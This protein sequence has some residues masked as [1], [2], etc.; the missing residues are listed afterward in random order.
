MAEDTFNPD[1]HAGFEELYDGEILRYTHPDFPEAHIGFSTVNT[2][3]VNGLDS[4]AVLEK[5]CPG[6]GAELAATMI[7]TGSAHG[8]RVDT[9]ADAAYQCPEKPSDRADG[10]VISLP[11]RAAVIPVADCL[12]ITILARKKDA[13]ADPMLG[14]LHAGWKGIR[15]GAQTAIVQAFQNSLDIPPKDLHVLIG[16]FGSEYAYDVYVKDAM[17]EGKH[18]INVLKEFEQAMDSAGRPLFTE[19]ILARAFRPHPDNTAK[20]YLDLGALATYLFIKAGV[21]EGQITLSSHRTI[22]EP[23]FRSSRVQIPEE[24]YNKLGPN[25]PNSIAQN[26]MCAVIEEQ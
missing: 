5:L 14:A 18:M 20:A 9:V 26:V 2:P 17:Q 15:Q 3:S 12:A 21:P 6:N 4:H 24:V 1:H 16:P 13:T 11:E 22:T 25:R 7:K 23:L 8:A 10:Y 19:E